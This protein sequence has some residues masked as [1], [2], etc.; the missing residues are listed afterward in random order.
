[1]AVPSSELGVQQVQLTGYSIL[2]SVLQLI[3]QAT[4]MWLIVAITVFKNSK[5]VGTFI[6]TWGTFGIANQ[7]QASSINPFGESETNPF[8]ASGDNSGL[9][10]LLSKLNKH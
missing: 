9:S 8:Q 1:M 3:P 4:C 10:A 7:T 2:H 6:R 5:I